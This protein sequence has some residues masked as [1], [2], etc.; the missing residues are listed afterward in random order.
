[1]RETVPGKKGSRDPG[2]RG[3]GGKWIGPVLFLQLVADPCGCPQANRRKQW[4]KNHARA[5]PRKG[6]YTFSCTATDRGDAET[7][8]G[9]EGVF[10]SAPFAFSG[11]RIEKGCQV[12]L[13]LH[14][15]RNPTIPAKPLAQQP[16]SPGYRHRPGL[17][18]IREHG[19]GGIGLQVAVEG[20]AVGRRTHC[21]SRSLPHGCFC[22]SMA[23]LASRIAVSVRI[24]VAVVGD[25]LVAHSTFPSGSQLSMSAKSNRYL[26]V[27]DGEVTDLLVAQQQVAAGAPPLTWPVM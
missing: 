8:K 12:R 19:P 24:V 18:D 13:I 4:Q 9:A 3:A 26:V 16:D 2:A 7:T 10:S 20:L 14:R 23:Q 6:R 25:T 11:L 17:G 22:Q 27:G 1:M 21:T 15:C 5:Q